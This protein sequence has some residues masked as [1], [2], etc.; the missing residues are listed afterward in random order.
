MNQ[1]PVFITTKDAKKHRH[2]IREASHSD[3]RGSDYVKELVGEIEKPSVV[4]PNQIPSI[5]I[6]LIS[7]ALPTTSERS[8][9]D[10]EW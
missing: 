10:Q 7:N 8:E 9:K 1:P 5:L 4:Q 6:T 3:Y 2:L